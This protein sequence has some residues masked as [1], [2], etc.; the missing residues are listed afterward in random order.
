MV[1][2]AVE[3]LGLMLVGCGGIL[4]MVLGLFF[5]ASLWGVIAWVC[6]IVSYWRRCCFGFVCV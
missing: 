5:E 2:F 1:L 3:L 4:F 6:L